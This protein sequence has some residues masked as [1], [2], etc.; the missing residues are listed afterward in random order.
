VA[1]NT[2]THVSAGP[3]VGNVEE[4]DVEDVELLDELELVLEESDDCEACSDSCCF[5]SSSVVALLV[6]LLSD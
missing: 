6:V 1:P 3:V 4:L 5:N 2:S